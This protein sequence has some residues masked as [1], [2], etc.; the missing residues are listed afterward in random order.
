MRLKSKTASISSDTLKHLI[1]VYGKRSTPAPETVTVRKNS[2][3]PTSV[4]PLGLLKSFVG[5]VFLGSIFY[6]I[7]ST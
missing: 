1:G 6:F 3:G 5:L 4:P 2:F 7:F